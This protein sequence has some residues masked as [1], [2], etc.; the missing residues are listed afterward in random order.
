V[1]SITR[2]AGDAH[3]TVETSRGVPVDYAAVLLAAPYHQTGIAITSPTLTEATLP[4]ALPDVPYVH[5]HVTLLTTTSPHPRPSYFGLPD[6]TTTRMPTMMLTTWD[7]VRARNTAA[8]EFNSLSYH[9]LIRGANGSDTE[10]EP[11]EWVVKIFSKER[12]S[13]AWLADMFMGQVGWVHRKEVAS[14]SPARAVQAL[15]PFHSGR[16]TRSF[17][18]LRPSRRSNLTLGC[19]T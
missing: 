6:N 19:T 4:A 15:T 14:F 2:K 17:S 12:V 13:D 16:H 10:G 3:W 11:K 8:P 5:L 18:R 1:K 9:G 7:G